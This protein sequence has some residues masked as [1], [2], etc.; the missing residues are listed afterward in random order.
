MKELVEKIR[1]KEQWPDRNGKAQLLFPSRTAEK[2][3]IH[4]AH[5]NIAKP[6][7]QK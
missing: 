2:V 4:T 6:Y 7:L 3:R 1:R 5:I